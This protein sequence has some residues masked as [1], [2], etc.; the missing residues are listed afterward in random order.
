[1]RCLS[2][3]FVVLLQLNALF[4]EAKTVKSTNSCPVA[5]P[6]WVTATDIT[7]SSITITWE[8][9][10]L[11]TWYKITRFDITNGIQLPDVIVPGST[12]TYT[13]DS[14]APGESIKF[15]LQ[16]TACTDPVEDDFGEEISAIFTTTFI[17]VDD[18]ASFT[19][20]G[21]PTGDYAIWPSG[22]LGAGDVSLSLI[23]AN[24]YTPQ[25]RVHKVKVYLLDNG[26]SYFAEFLTWSQ[27]NTE[28][29]SAV[30]VMYWKPLNWSA[31]VTSSPGIGATTNSV[32]FKLQGR[33]FFTLYGASYSGNTATIKIKNDRS[34]VIYYSKLVINEDNPCYNVEFSGPED[35]ISDT[36]KRVETDS[37]LE[38]RTTITGNNP[39]NTVNISPNPF[40]TS[41]SIQYSL[42]EESPVTLSLYDHTGRVL[43]YMQLP[44]L[45]AG[46]Y[47]TGI[48]TTDLPVGIYQ[49]GFQT[50]KKRNMTTLVKQY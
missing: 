17:I 3:L 43:R 11:V 39:S 28:Q 1:M 29:S 4:V 37:E 7:T 34:T 44:S 13:S 22:P 20:P 5:P 21:A 14:H 6:S 31:G 50:N 35:Q 47:N 23:N 16:A 40:S 48:Y 9:E 46:E 2:L 41:L 30:R 8:A 42:D 45:P 38:D 26:V 32:V 25:V 27:C 19:A 15:G 12:T 10:T 24:E 18:I 49:L 36:Q 33:P